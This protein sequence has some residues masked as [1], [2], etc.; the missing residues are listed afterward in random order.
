MSDTRNFGIPRV[1][2]VA[3][4]LALSMTAGGLMAGMSVQAAERPV[5]VSQNLYEEGALERYLAEAKKGDIFSQYVLGHMYSTGKSVE[6]DY[7]KGL[8][9]YRAAAEA[10]YAPSQLA[11]GSMYYAGQGVEAD[12]SEAV[13]WFEKAAKRG[14]VRAQANL[15]AVYLAGEGVEADHDK[16]LHWYREAVLGGHERSRYYLA[17]MYVHGMG[18]DAPDYV[19]AYALL[20]PLVKEGDDSSAEL[21]ASFEDDMSRT[22]LAEAREFLDGPQTRERMVAALD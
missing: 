13:R 14:Y 4:A 2:R 20:D 11:L 7:K 5:G 6:Q 10:G 15:A 9:W 21:L 16:A 19:A 8:R 3:R 22:E 18:M 17:T 1:G 12:A